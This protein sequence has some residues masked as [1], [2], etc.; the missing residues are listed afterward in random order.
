QTLAPAFVALT[1]AMTLLGPAPSVAFLL[2]ATAVNSARRRVSRPIWLNNLSS[3]AAFPI[4][5]AMLAR[6]LIGNVHS[7][8]AAHDLQRPSFGL[9]VFGV[10]AVSNALNF[11]L[12][13]LDLRILRGRPLLGQVRTIFLPLLP[14]QFAAAALA[15]ILAVAY[16]AAG[17]TVLVAAVL[18]LLI[19]QF[20]V[21]ALVR[22]EERAD[23]LETH[24]MRLASLQLGVLTTLTET[25]AMR[26]R[27]TADH[28]AVVARYSRDLA[29]AA[30]CSAADQ[31]LAH[32]A[33]LLHDIGKFTLP[34]RVLRAD[35][36]SDQ[37]WETIHRHPLDGA[38]L[39][40]RLDGYGPV[41]EVILAHHEHVDGSGYP[42]GL[43]G[44]E[45]PLLARIVAIC[46][47]YDAMTAHHSYRP[48]MTPQDA[49]K[50][51]RR[52]AGRQFD[53]ELVD[54]F[55]NMIEEQPAPDARGPGT[56]TG[57]RAELEFER[58]VR[59]IA[60]PHVRS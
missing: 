25:L 19:F 44:N 21:L 52:V 18:V 9:A 36:L 49:L 56:E 57:F 11:A 6:L 30:G 13:A 51:L 31:E 28:L 54:L 50:E 32:T 3:T 15:A 4:A 43:I 1:L 33:G 37:D 58:R 60:Q 12:V 59:A 20:L 38:T 7:A 39:V 2:P 35:V 22:S 14:A 26:D 55:V 5:G 23:Q 47:A 10:F 17:I 46:E 41:A 34:D 29:Q 42:S 8:G 48:P 27:I 45:I 24:I 53:A 40:G 16:V